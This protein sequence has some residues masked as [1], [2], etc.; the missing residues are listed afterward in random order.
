MRKIRCLL[1]FSVLAFLLSASPGSTIAAE[2]A[3]EFYSGDIIELTAQAIVIDELTGRKSFSLTQETI[4]CIDGFLAESWEDLTAVRTVTISTGLNSSTARRIDNTAIV[5]D[6]G[7]LHF[8]P[9]L[10]E[11]KPRVTTI[12]VQGKLVQVLEIQ[13]L[14]VRAGIDTGPLDGKMGPL[15]ENA[16]RGFQKSRGL[17]ETVEITPRLMNQ[18]RSATAT[19]LP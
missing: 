5:V 10:P 18:L 11:C 9:V 13:R 15:T 17:P 16:I 14:L 8:Q 12:D 1:L 6:M 4:L 2:E 7:G 3:M 19:A